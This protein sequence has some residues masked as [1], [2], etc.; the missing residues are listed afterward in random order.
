VLRLKE[1]EKPAPKN[2]EVLIRVYAA[3]INSLFW[4]LVRAGPFF[5]RLMV[6]GLLKP[7]TP[8]LGADL[9]GRIKVV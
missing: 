5:I 2:D 4:Q 9:A 6:G 7:I 1:L 8:I 3:S